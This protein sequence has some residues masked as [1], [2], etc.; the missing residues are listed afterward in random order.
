MN[1][2]LLGAVREEQKVQRVVVVVG[3]GRV[4]GLQQ[5][6]GAAGNLVRSEVRA[7][8]EGIALII[9]T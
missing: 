7:I 1:N 8:N 9:S 5:E 6:L 4:Y 3:E 2:C